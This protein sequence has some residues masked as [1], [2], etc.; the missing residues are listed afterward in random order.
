MSYIGGI[1]SKG[2]VDS[3]SPLLPPSED[4]SVDASGTTKLTSKSIQLS[5]MLV[6][7]E[8]LGGFVVIDVPNLDKALPLAQQAPCDQP[9][10]GAVEIRPLMPDPKS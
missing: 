5:G 10:A 4:R 2:I 8:Q 6:V 1:Q 7:K 9:G 3:A